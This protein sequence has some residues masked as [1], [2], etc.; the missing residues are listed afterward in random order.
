MY[1]EPVNASVPSQLPSPVCLCGG[2]L[3]L[4]DTDLT[5]PLS[6][7]NICQIWFSVY[8]RLIVVCQSYSHSGVT[9]FCPRGF[10][11]VPNTFLGH[12]NCYRKLYENEKKLGH[13]RTF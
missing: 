6:A 13:A 1:Y 3:F 2:Q 11:L 4:V 5:A 10:R 9:L 12:S 7:V 8:E